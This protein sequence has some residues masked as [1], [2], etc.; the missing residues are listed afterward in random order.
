MTR[1]F[2]VK[3]GYQEV[4]AGGPEHRAYLEAELVCKYPTKEMRH[5][6]I[7]KVRAAYG[8]DHAERLMEDVRRMWARKRR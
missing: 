1:V 7:E 6:Y 4:V 8:D 2:T 5:Q 3:I